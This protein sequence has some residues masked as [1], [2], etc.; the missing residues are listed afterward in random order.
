[1][2]ASAEAIGIVADALRRFNI[3]QSVVDPV[4]IQLLS[5]QL[6]VGQYNDM[7]AGDGIDIRRAAPS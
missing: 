5:M 4:C 3:N 2:L 7:Q 1:M 6:T